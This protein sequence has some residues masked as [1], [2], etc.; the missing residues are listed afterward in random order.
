[1][2]FDKIAFR[3]KK[4]E[5]LFCHTKKNTYFYTR[6]KCVLIQNIESHADRKKFI[7]TKIDCTA[8]QWPC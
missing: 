8:G 1:M 7:F 4:I 3:R 2:N 5:R 6:Q